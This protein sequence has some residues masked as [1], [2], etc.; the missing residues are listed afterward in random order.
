MSNESGTQPQKNQRR[1]KLMLVSERNGKNVFSFSMPLWVTSILFVGLAMMVALA[2]V[3][4]IMKTPLKTYLPGYL[5]VTKRAVVVESSMRLDSLERENDLR[6]AYLD[7]IMSILLDRSKTDSIVSFDSAVV[8]IQDTLLSASE[9]EMAFRDAYNERERFGLDAIDASDPAFAA[10]TFLSPAKGK[11]AVPEDD[12]DIV[13]GV[14]R[15]ELSRDMPVIAPLEGTVISCVFLIG[16]GYQVT[17]QHSGEYVTI[18]SHLASVL[19]EAGQQV[20]TGRVIGH[21]G[22]EKDPA[23]SWFGLQL[24]HKGKAIDPAAVM[25]LE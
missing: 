25:S 19:V 9:R 24:W 16:Q 14:T 21:A 8:R 1:Y 3:I 10:I 20:K 13:S 11:V 22:N 2:I 6:I 7:N 17:L 23:Q 12:D 5:D 18:F 15:V 4:F